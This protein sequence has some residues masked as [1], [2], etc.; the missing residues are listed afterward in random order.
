MFLLLPY[1]TCIPTIRKA[2]LNGSL[3]ILEGYPLKNIS[4]EALKC[5][6]IVELLVDAQLMNT[7]SNLGP[8]Y[9][10]I[11]KVFIVNIPEDFKN[12]GRKD[13]KKVH[14]HGCYFRFPHI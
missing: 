7:V 6:E 10:K 11:I 5:E 2:F 9:L 14:V 13:F 12:A 3:C 8:Y 4:K 1:I